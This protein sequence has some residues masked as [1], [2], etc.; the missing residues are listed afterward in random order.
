MS[1]VDLA[2]RVRITHGDRVVDE[3]ELELERLAARRLPHLAGL[4]A[5]VGVDDRRPA[6]PHVERHADGVVHERLVR[7]RALDLGQLR[8]RDVGVLLDRR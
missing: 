7:R 5:V 1:S 2:R 3:D 4:E 6:G 8:A